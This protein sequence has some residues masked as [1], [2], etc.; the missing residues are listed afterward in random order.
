MTASAQDRIVRALAQAAAQRLCRRAVARLQKMR[1]TL[2]GDDSELKN[3]WDEICAQVQGDE[4]QFWDAY[5][6]SMND[7]LAWDVAHLPLYE[8]QALWLQ[9]PEWEDWDCQ[10]DERKSGEPP[11]SEDDIVRYLVHEH[12]LAEAGRW[13]N[14]RI[15]AFLDRSSM[16]D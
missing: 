9:S 5:E 7:A 15:R 16:W 10:D 6:S 12:L 14:P 3:T 8:K 4:S 13:S 1:Q 11:V 2:S